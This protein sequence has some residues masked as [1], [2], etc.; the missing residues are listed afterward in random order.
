MPKP[1]WLLCLCLLS[2]LH[3]ATAQPFELPAAAA[4]DPAA[5]AQ[6]MPKL[7]DAVIASYKEGDHRAFLDNLFRL[8]IA[9]GQ[10]AE[11][12]RSLAVAARVCPRPASRPR[13]AATQVLY[14]AFA[15]A[16]ARERDRL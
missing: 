9:A 10:Y 7:A 8:Q 11:A 14:A 12:G 5:L 2:A 3:G 15:A 4:E 6:A 16:K 13:P 1:V